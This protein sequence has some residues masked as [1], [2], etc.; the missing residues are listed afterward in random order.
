[1]LMSPL[2]LKL[3]IDHGKLKVLK[4]YRND[5]PVYRK[6]LEIGYNLQKK[7]FYRFW[8]A[9]VD[10]EEHFRSII[11]IF[12]KITYLASMYDL[13][14]NTDIDYCQTYFCLLCDVSYAIF[15]RELPYNAEHQA[16]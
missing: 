16:R 8:S 13:P 1:M 3:D 2:T 11:S 9:F 10:C 6:L 4:E 7:I 5:D 14:M 15:V 12:R